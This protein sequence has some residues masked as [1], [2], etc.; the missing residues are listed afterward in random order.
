MK[1]RQWGTE[2]GDREEERERV[3]RVKERKTVEWRDGGWMGREGRS[4]I[5]AFAKEVANLPFTVGQRG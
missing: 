2:R 5:I 1:R 4:N 3:G